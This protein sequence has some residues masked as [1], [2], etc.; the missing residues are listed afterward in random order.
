MLWTYFLGKNHFIQAN[1]FI[2]RVNGSLARSVAKVEERVIEE[3]TNMAEENIIIP[4]FFVIS[5]EK[6]SIM[7]YD[8]MN[9]ET[10]IAFLKIFLNDF[11]VMNREAIKSK[12]DMYMMPSK[13][14]VVNPAK[15]IASS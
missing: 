2:A 14:L 3:S 8:H 10:K 11:F 9:D 4:S 7:L 6:A 12:G 1:L 5:A 13:K 15:N